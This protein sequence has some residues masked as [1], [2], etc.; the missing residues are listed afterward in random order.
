MTWIPYSPWAALTLASQ[1]KHLYFFFYAGM[2]QRTYF[3]RQPVAVEL[4]EAG[5]SVFNKFHSKRDGVNYHFI[6][7]DAPDSSRNTLG[8]I[9][10]WI[11]P[12]PNDV[13][14]ATNSGLG[15]GLAGIID[16]MTTDEV[17]SSQVGPRDYSLR[18]GGLSLSYNLCLKP[19][20]VNQSSTICGGPVS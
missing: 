2:D 16:R 1:I 17:H 11:N 6:S 4:S 10:N 19:I 7:G 20:L 5:M 15:N 14:I 13:G 18:D 12:P 8:R 3:S 9:A